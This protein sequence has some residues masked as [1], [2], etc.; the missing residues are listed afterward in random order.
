MFAAEPVTSIPLPCEL[1]MRT[2]VQSISSAV[3]S[4]T[5]ASAVVS[6]GSQAIEKFTNW[7]D[8]P[9]EFVLAQKPRR[10]LS[11]SMFVS[12]RREVTLLSGPLSRSMP[13]PYA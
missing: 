3:P 8:D 4:E 7:P 11:N 12:F 6:A 2:L 5:K 10:V 9:A 13:C 1:V